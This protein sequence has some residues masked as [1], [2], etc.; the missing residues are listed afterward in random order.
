MGG[1]SI[2]L[3]KVLW[4]QILP[5]KWINKTTIFPL[6]M[7]E[8]EEKFAVLSMLQVRNESTNEANSRSKHCPLRPNCIL[9]TFMLIFYFLLTWCSLYYFI[10][11]FKNFIL[12]FNLGYY[13][14]STYYSNANTGHITNSISLQQKLR[15][16]QQFDNEWF[17]LFIYSYLFIYLF[18]MWGSRGKNMSQSWKEH[19]T[20]ACTSFH[21][22]LSQ[23]DELA[24]NHNASALTAFKCSHVGNQWERG[25][26]RDP[27]T[28]A[29]ENL[30][31]RGWKVI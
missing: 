27:H 18:K 8:T 6:P 21:R 26:W 22:F 16:W 28:T 12:D 17:V 31:R 25:T 5:R 15:T 29:G 10:F 4:N 13:F 14:Q 3:N 24:G 1:I 23:S 19:S 7:W 2:K 30:R 11:I 9:L 20:K